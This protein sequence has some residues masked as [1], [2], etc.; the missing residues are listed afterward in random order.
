MITQVSGA[1]VSVAG[2][3]TKTPTSFTIN[4]DEITD[5]KGMAT[6]QLLDGTDLAGT[7]RFSITPPAGSSLGVMFDQKLNLA[8]P[9][10]STRLASRIALRGNILDSAGHPLSNVAITARPSLRFLWTLDVAPQAFVAAIPAAT[11]VSLDTGEFVVWVDANV[12][13]VWG[14]YDLLIEPP[15]AAQAPAYTKSEI[16][17]PRDGTLDAVSLGEITLPEA[18]F[19]HGRITSPTG[20]SLEKAELKLYQVST[21]LGLCSEVAHAPTSCPIPAQLQGRATSDSDGI[22]RVTLPR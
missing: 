18:A 12:A 10:I 19:V 15:P 3:T 14:H 6:L 4:D 11:A 1:L 16:E 9:P 13:T 21:A 5:D 8:G 2:T 17:I 22:V 7:Y 20:D